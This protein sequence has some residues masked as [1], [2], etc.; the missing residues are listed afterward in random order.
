MHGFTLLEIMVGMAIM[1]IVLAVGVPAMAKWVTAAKARS[2]IGFYSE[3]LVLARQ[4]AI[5][6]NG[7]SR[8]VFA[9]NTGNGQYDWQ[10]DVCFPTVLAPTCGAGTGA[11]STTTAPAAGDPETAADPAK[12]AGFRSVARSAASLSKAAVIAPELL[13]AGTSS[14]YFNSLGW[15]DTS[16]AQ[17]LSSIRLSPSEAIDDEVRPVAVVIG[18][19]GTAIKCDWSVA[20]PDSRACP[21]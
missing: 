19:A 20:I 1:G 16:V 17:R 12:A 5:S 13:P 21:P 3:G 15:V 8:I 9:L 7:S 4:Q 10:V 11:W 6:H 2:V 14:I 18:L